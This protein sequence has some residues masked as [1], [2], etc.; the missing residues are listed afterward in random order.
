MKIK[1]QLFATLKLKAGSDSIEV[2]LDGSTASVQQVIDA[3]LARHPALESSLRSILVAV[4][5]E[6]APRDLMVTESDVVAF[7]PP[8]SGG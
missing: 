8:V 2:E 6:Y 3:A 4:N 7:F 5:K 1:I